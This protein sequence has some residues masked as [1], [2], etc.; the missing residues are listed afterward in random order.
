MKIEKDIRRFMQ[1]NRI[2]VPKDDR[3]MKELVRQ[4]DLLPTPA[5]FSSEEEKRLQD[6]IRLVKL[7]RQTLTRHY[8]RQAVET[9]IVNVLLCVTIFFAATMLISP[10]M[11]YDSSVLQFIVR[12]RY[13]LAGLACVT[14]L[15]LS[16]AR[17]D[18][19]RL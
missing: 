19:F 7:I 16:L 3:F 9:I 18:L 11:E 2:P 5:S 13:L 4:M 10:A 6:N 15:L 17:T 1:V 14:S 12:W 8:R